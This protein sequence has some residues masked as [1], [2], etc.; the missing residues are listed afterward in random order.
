MLRGHYTG[1]GS[2]ETPKSVQNTIQPVAYDLAATGMVLRSGGADGADEAFEV[3]CVR[4]CNA[5]KTKIHTAMEIYLPW[6][7]FN[8]RPDMNPPYHWEYPLREQASQMAASVHPA[9]YNCNDAARRLHTRNV[10]QV[11][12]LNLNEPSKLLLCWTRGG[13]AV[14]G[15]RTAIVLAEKYC[16]PV[17]NLADEQYINIAP[18]DLLA[19]ILPILKAA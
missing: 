2:R 15:T 14:G 17:I 3:G 12:G 9:W 7:G 16:V 8:G 6:Q 5:D 13:R 11:F 1:V 19:E 10:F 18:V 4:Y